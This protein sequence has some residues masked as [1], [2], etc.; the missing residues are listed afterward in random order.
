MIH[1]PML[2]V[3]IAATTTSNNEKNHM[4]FY[5][6][7]LNADASIINTDYTIV[8]NLSTAP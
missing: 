6:W 8:N 5:L 1:L 2:L 3:A 4:G 7:P